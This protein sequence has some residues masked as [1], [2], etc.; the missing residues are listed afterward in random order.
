[1]IQFIKALTKERKKREDHTLLLHRNANSSYLSCLDKA[2]KIL[3]SFRS[4]LSHYRL[5]S[6]S[7]WHGWAKRI[8]TR[9]F[10]FCIVS[11]C[12]DRGLFVG[13]PVDWV[14]PWVSCSYFHESRQFRSRGRDGGT[15]DER[16]INH[17]VSH[18]T[19]VCGRKRF[20]TG[21][22]VSSSQWVSYFKGE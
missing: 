21:P 7:F 12:I 9:G 6:R 5:L 20:A 15:V 3:D 10:F 17:L 19:F 13:V 11:M 22:N 16:M 18:F 14:I 1:M 2:A 8:R 4:R